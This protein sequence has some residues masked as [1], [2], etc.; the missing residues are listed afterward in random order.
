LAPAALPQ[1]FAISMS[2]MVFFF[3]LPIVADLMVIDE[4]I[5]EI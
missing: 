4:G 1:F 2:A 5:H 3:D